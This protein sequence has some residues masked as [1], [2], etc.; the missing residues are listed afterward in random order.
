MHNFHFI[1]FI[2]YYE[3]KKSGK[4]TTKHNFLKHTSIQHFVTIIFYVYH[5]SEQV[6]F[7]NELKIND[8][9]L[10]LDPGHIPSKKT[11]VFAK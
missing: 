11:A 1:S 10:V 2:H 5:L 6:W 4:C 8:I 7:L 9:N 3:Q